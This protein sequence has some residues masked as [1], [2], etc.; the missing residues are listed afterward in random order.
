MRSLRWCLA[1]APLL[2]ACWRDA[3][4]SL[5]VR[6][7]DP[8]TLAVTD[9]L[10]GLTGPQ[11]DSLHHMSEGD[12][13]IPVAWLV[14]LENPATGKLFLDDVERFGMLRDPADPYGLPIGLSASEPRDV[15]ELAGKMVG[16]SCAV[17]HT[18]HLTYRGTPFLIEGGSGTVDAE[19]FERELMAA[20]D[21]LKHPSRFAAWL[22]R[23]RE[24]RASGDTGLKA[25]LPSFDEFAKLFPKLKAR[26]ASFGAVRD[27][28]EHTERTPS[29]YGRIDAFGTGRNLLFPDSK[30]PLTA[31]VRYPV[32]YD[33]YRH[34]WL[35]W[36]ANTNSII[37]RNIGQAIAAGAIVDPVTKHS[38]LLPMNHY[39]LEELSARIVPPRWPVAI[40]GAIDTVLAAEGR[41]LYQQQC[42]AC[43]AL[44]A[45]TD[46]ERDTLISY[47]DVGTDPQRATSAAIPLK[48]G[49][50]YPVVAGEF[51]RVVK[52]TAFRQSGIDAAQQAK[53]EGNRARSEWR[54]TQSYA[55]RPL[56]AIWSH[57]PFL[58]NGSVPTL[59][60]LL[61]PPSQRPATFTLGHHEFDPV[62]VGLAATGPMRGPPFTFDTGLTGNSNAG[63]LWGTT[64]SDAQRKALLEYLKTL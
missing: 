48:G 43:H 29:G 2:T 23:V 62:K 18:G 10:Q 42:V 4:S 24:V 40:F 15:G 35:H 45:G 37:E 52:D 41:A 60:D 3:S 54:V 9:S 56:T 64:L 5:T 14:A 50:L 57:P 32:T 61:L 27:L 59:H 11:R 39:A 36:D 17:C 38:S 30:V 19:G 58:H 47:K 13:F 34:T 31:P 21:S 55:A 20:M 8:R 12:E 63:H 49:G 51:L 46:T 44:R 1:V 6:M 7:P 28:L 22:T 33:A 26:L 25:Q 53:L 16:F